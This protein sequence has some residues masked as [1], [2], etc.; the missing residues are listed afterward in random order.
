MM[1]SNASFINIKQMSGL[2]SL[3]CKHMVLAPYLL[4]TV[5]SCATFFLPFLK[6]SFALERPL[7]WCL[8]DKQWLGA[9]LWWSHTCPSMA[10]MAN[11][12]VTSCIN[13]IENILL[14]HS[15]NVLCYLLCFQ[16]S[17]LLLPLLPSY[18][19]YMEDDSTGCYLLSRK[20]GLLFIR[21]PMLQV[22]E[23]FKMPFSENILRAK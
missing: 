16:V 3:L 11:F 19:L 6:A 9:C 22:W 8:S 20:R 12:A 13:A 4:V 2:E 1:C 7:K 23:I 5:A 14:W 17:T 15:E 18:K 10:L 21:E